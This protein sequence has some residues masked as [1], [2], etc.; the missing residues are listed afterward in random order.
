M[1]I[2]LLLSRF[3]DLIDRLSLNGLVFVSETMMKFNL[4]FVLK[5]KKNRSLES[6][7]M[8]NFFFSSFDHW[9]RSI[10]DDWISFWRK[11][12]NTI[13]SRFFVQKQ[14]SFVVSVYSSMIIS[15]D[16]VLIHRSEFVVN[17]WKIFLRKF[18]F[19]LKRKKDVCRRNTRV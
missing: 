1:M 12:S 6:H 5:E 13:E 16:L 4:D 8:F 3:V 15:F 2:F 14:I 7:F 10:N 11:L 19:S 18:L 17:L 9:I